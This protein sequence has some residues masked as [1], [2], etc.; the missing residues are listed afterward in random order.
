MTEDSRK[1][2]DKMAEEFIKKHGEE[3]GKQMLNE[4]AKEKS[5]QVRYIK[6]ESHNLRELYQQYSE[7]AKTDPEALLQPQRVL[8]SMDNEGLKFVNGTILSPADQDL[9][10]EDG[11]DAGD[12]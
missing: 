7:T 8:L 4:D 1:K 9:I 11:K 2:Y 5:F 12:L 10:D 3:K 6:C